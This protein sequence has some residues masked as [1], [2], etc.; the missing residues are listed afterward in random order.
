MIV[1]NEPIYLLLFFLIVFA[2][3]LSYT[4]RSAGSDFPCAISLYPTQPYR[5]SLIF[6]RLLH[7]GASLCRW[8]AVIL[9]VCLLADPAITRREQVY[10]TQGSEIIVVLDESPSMGALD[11]GSLSRFEIAKKVIQNFV[12]NRTTE[13]IGLVGFATETVLRVPPTLDYDYFSRTLEEVPLLTLGDATSLGMGILHGILYL[14]SGG[15]DEKILIVLTDGKQNSGEY[16]SIYASEIAASYGIVLH[17]IG[18]GTNESVPVNIEGGED[19]VGL[20]GM[21]ADS[22][23]PVLL[24]EIAEQTGGDFYAVNNVASL[25]Q[26][27]LTIESKSETKN[28]YRYI[29]ES[30]PIYR[31]C[32][33]L[34]MILFCVDLIIRKVFLRESFVW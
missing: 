15:S 23:D 22:Y 26:A 5:P 32:L 17:S 25:E 3:Y 31:E 27:F 33:L 29:A 2:M 6:A 4:G 12:K 19:G 20:Q 16:S 14:R 10:T 21:I 18:I 11:A 24:Q 13:A 30:R 9:L 1:F 28:E 34:I 7:R 8:I